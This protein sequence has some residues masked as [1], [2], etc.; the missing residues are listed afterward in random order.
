MRRDAHSRW[1]GDI[2]GRQFRA[3]RPSGAQREMYAADTHTGTEMKAG[4]QKLL[5][6]EAETKRCS[7]E[8]RA[9]YRAAGPTEAAT[10]HSGEALCGATA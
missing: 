7:P 2:H 9:S 1:R 3:E 10:P 6:A 4:G 5:C 8:R